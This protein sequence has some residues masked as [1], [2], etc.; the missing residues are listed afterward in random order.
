MQAVFPPELEREIFEHTALVSPQS[1]PLLIR[2]ARRVYIW[3]EP[4]LYRVIRIGEHK[5]AV[6]ALYTL[7]ER[8]KPADFFH[9]AVHHLTLETTHS[10]GKSTDLLRLCTGV[11]NFGC[12]NLTLSFSILPIIAGMHQL[13]RFS[14]NLQTLFGNVESINFGV[15]ALQ[16]LTHLDMFDASWDAP[17]LIAALPQLQALTHLCLNTDYWDSRHDVLSACHSSLQLL[18]FQ[19]SITFS[20][21]GDSEYDDIKDDSG[22]QD[23]R[24]VVGLYDEYFD[25]WEAEAR[26]SSTRIWAEA[27]DF[28]AKKQRGE[29]EATR[30]WIH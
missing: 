19:W 20:S 12:A 23:A 8:G 1:I 13:R 18:L 29:I 3:V 26:G 14:G 4:L 6:A 27:E 15:P 11:R 10:I 9:Q 25:E 28:V 30:F 7:L 17:T 24:I 21:D 2:V 16:S 5:D 22:V